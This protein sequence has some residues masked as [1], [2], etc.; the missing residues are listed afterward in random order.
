[1][2][3]R[4]IAAGCSNTHKDNVSLFSFPRNPGLRERW[5]KQVRRTRADFVEPSAHSCLCSDHFSDDCFET[6]QVMA[7]KLGIPKRKKLKPDAV[8]TI[9]KRMT[10]S[11]R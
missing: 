3:K 7:A 2:G 10:A 6:A 8:S 4:C 9:F 11:R 5:T 1:M